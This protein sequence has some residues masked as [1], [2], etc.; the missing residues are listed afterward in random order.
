MCERS[1]CHWSS[2]DRLTHTYY[3]SKF[4]SKYKYY[5]VLNKVYVLISTLGVPV[6]EIIAYYYIYY[7][8]VFDGVQVKRKKSKINIL[9]T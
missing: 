3:C 9:F 7:V 6:L 4:Q 1:Q 5:C 8:N 2:L